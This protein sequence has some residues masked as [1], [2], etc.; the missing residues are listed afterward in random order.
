[1]K[2]LINGRTAEEIKHDIEWSAFT[3]EDTG[4]DECK[5]ANDCRDMK[6]GYEIARNALALIERLEAQVPRWIGVEERFPEK[7]NGNNQIYITEEVIGFDGECAY[8]GQYKVYKYDGHWTFF[9]GNFFRD[10]ITH[11]MPLPEPPKEGAECKD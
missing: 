10:D 1:M 4:C 7:L 11:W 6:P 8:I 5:F 9:D 3:C 2:E